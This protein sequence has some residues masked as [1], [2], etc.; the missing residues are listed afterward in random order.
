MIAAYEKGTPWS[1]RSAVT[2]EGKKL[3]FGQTAAVDRKK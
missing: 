1:S 3:L 2:D